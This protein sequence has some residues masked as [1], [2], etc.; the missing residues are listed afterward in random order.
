MSDPWTSLG[1]ERQ[2]EIRAEWLYL[3]VILSMAWDDIELILHT[4]VTLPSS[5][6]G[7]TVVVMGPNP[8]I[9]I[10]LSEARAEIKTS[11]FFTANSSSASSTDLNSSG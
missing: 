7:S 1:Y 3:D 5:A 2:T 11:L 6:N 4:Y 9:L 8:S 10:V